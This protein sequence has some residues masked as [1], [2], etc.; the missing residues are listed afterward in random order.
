MYKGSLP[1]E[2]DRFP[3][4]RE[5]NERKSLWLFGRNPSPMNDRMIKISI[6][7]LYWGC[8][9]PFDYFIKYVWELQ[10]KEKPDY[11][12]L[13]DLLATLTLRHAFD[14]LGMRFDLV[15]RFDLAEPF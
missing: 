14:I 6:K 10:F 3:F 12:R 7:E 2:L 4:G 9:R 8:S 15:N 13:R 1:W 11:Q 5:N